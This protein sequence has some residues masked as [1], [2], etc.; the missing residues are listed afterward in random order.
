VRLGTGLS[1]VA[2][3]ATTTAY[4]DQRQQAAEHFAL[5]ESAER[6]QDWRS[7]I[8]EYA[9]AY[10]L[11]PHPSVLYNIAR[12]HERLEDWAQAVEFYRRYLAE[13]PAASD[14]D[15][16]EER[17]AVLEERAQAA[18]PRPRAGTG[19]LI[20]H[21]QP[22]GTEVVVDGKP[23]GVTPFQ[24]EIAA[25]PHH[26][27]LRS[28]GHRPVERDVDVPPTG[29]EQIRETLVPTADQPPEVE[30]A[31]RSFSFVLGGEYGYGL[32]ARTQ[33]RLAGVVGLRL[34]E[35]VEVDFLAGILSSETM[36]GVENR[37]YFNRGATRVFS[38]VAFTRGT[39]S[40]VDRIPV[41]AV[42]AG[43][44]YLFTGTGP[45]ILRWGLQGALSLRAAFYGD[46]PDPASDGDPSGETG[47]T[48]VLAG[49]ILLN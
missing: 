6:R 41:S 3:V 27:V 24:G 38:R 9:R 18:R 39:Y 17:I 48:L 32:G 1:L 37:I 40:G 14:R 35:F 8:D 20:V 36:L 42:E 22:D 29:S 30:P 15:K 13:D 5:A 44:G 21:A 4:A 46:D 25:G 47:Y 31:R 11:A 19:W 23:I 43:V 49:G 33:F 16:V 28:A 2:L 45:Q 7:A 12:N 10:A 34:L 26:V